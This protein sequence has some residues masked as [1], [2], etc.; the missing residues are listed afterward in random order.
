MKKKE[1]K[2]EIKTYMENWKKKN[3][4]I[5]FFSLPFDSTIDL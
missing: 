3:K 4:C 1:N 5:L 2:A